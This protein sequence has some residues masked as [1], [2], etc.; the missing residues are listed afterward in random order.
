M[1]GVAC[2]NDYLSLLP[3]TLQWISRRLDA[4]SPI[5]WPLWIGGLF[6]VYVA[7]VSVLLWFLRGSVWPVQCA[8][9]RTSKGRPCR[10]WVPGEWMRCRHHNRRI[11]YRYGHE[12]VKLQRWQTLTRGNKVVDRPDSG[13][14]ALRL[15][16]AKSTLLYERGYARPPLAVIRLIPDKVAGGVRRLREARLRTPA[17]PV[18]AVR[19]DPLSFEPIATRRRT[20]IAKGLEQVV[21]ATQFATLAFCIAIVFT[22]V[23]I[24]T[25]DTAQSILQ[26]VATLGFVLAW[27]ATSAGVYSRSET[28]LKGAC[29]KALKW[30]AG[31]FVPVALLNLAFT[32]MNKSPA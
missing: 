21:R 3:S 10:N 15:R 13:V 19:A 6:P 14:G 5:P 2:V 1:T 17:P 18:E 9:P 29:L 25:R 12:V 23:A 31:I 16:P 27:A 8:Y 28:W 26:Y 4:A 30:W 24:L 20:D 7:G 32:V 11:R 22:I